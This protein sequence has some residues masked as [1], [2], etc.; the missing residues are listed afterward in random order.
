MLDQ[1][2]KN[3]QPHMD[4]VIVELQGEIA[5]Y[6]TGKAE[7]ALVE[8][9]IVASYGA[10]MPLKQLATIATP[11]SNQIVITPWDKGNLTQIEAAIREQ[12]AQMNP[13]NDGAQIRITLPPMSGERR[14]E[15]IK[16]VHKKGEEA[17]VALRQ[18][19]EDAWQEVKTAEKQK[20]LTEDDRYLGED[21]L[22]KMISEY[23]GRVSEM[24]EGKEREILS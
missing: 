11:E 3:T 6:H 14:Q 12:N 8:D 13:S 20:Q 10:K 19:R 2:L 21:K 17:R 7:A 1:I 18:I 23:N 4:K 9:I 15:L 24:V 5:K 16:A 22:N